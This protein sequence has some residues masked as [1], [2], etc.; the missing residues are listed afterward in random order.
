MRKQTDLE[1]KLIELGLRLSYK[2]YT[3]KH[4]EYVKE[5]V[6]EGVMEIP[7]HGVGTAITLKVVIDPTRKL[8]LDIRNYED[9]NINDLRD[10]VDK[11]EQCER[12]ITDT[13]KVVMEQ[14]EQ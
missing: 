5:Y 12:T 11:L 2:T 3:G 8:I 9:L 4:S 1:K 13:W 6:Y 10:M 14:R 7:Y